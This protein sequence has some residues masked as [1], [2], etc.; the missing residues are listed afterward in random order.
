MGSVSGSIRKVLLNGLSFNAAADGNFAKTPKLEKE[1]VPHS[2][3]N[4]IK[5]TRASGNVESAKLIC[6]PT[7]Y[8]T[9]EGLA[10]SLD[11]FSMSYEMA[12]GSVWR[13]EGTIMLDNY[14]SEEH[15]VEVTMIPLTGTWELFAS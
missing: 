9:L 3:G 12:D 13:T 15:S 1:A 5:H 4:M 7:E 11:P 2:G 6:T 8:E 10:D 14:E